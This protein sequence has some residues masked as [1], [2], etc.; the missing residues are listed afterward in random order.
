MLGF[1]DASQGDNVLYFVLCYTLI[2][3]V[4]LMEQLEDWLH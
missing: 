2:C 3:N 4:T 1:T